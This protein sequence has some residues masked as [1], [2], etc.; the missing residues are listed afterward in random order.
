MR[1]FCEDCGVKWFVR[2]GDV[3]PL[4]APDCAACGG[5]LRPLDEHQAPHARGDEPPRAPSPSVD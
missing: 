4:A 1:Y 5:S 2:E 3:Q